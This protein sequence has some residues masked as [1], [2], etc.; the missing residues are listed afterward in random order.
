[1]QYFL[2][3][4]AEAAV[5]SGT[6]HQA[7]PRALDQRVLDTILKCIRFGRPFGIGMLHDYYLPVGR[8][9][10]ILSSLLHRYEGDTRGF[11]PEETFGMLKY[12]WE[13]AS[14]SSPFEL[15]YLTME[16][17]LAD[18]AGPPREYVYVRAK[19]SLIAQPT[20][21][22]DGGP[23]TIGGSGGRSKKD[24]DGKDSTWSQA[25]AW[26]SQGGSWSGGSTW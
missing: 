6:L 19:Q 8:I 24:K 26:K 22:A 12:S 10:A 18:T 21:A 2:L 4:K 25:P 11:S 13:H 9:S 20:L 7:A 23:A 1:M 16:A 17:T 5:K 3:T 15:M 14:S